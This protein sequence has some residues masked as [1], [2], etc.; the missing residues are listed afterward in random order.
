MNL[1]ARTVGML[2]LREIIEA[3]EALS[4]LEH[5][6]EVPEGQDGWCRMGTGILP[7]VSDSRR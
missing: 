4:P 3:G 1:K 6:S 2:L 5:F 7:R